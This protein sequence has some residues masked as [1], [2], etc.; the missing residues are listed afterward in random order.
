MSQTDTVRESTE[1]GTGRRQPLDD[2]SKRD[3]HYRCPSEATREMSAMN[4][5]LRSSFT[6][7]VVLSDYIQRT[8]Y[9]SQLSDQGM[10]GA[11]IPSSVELHAWL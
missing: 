1:E 3:T 10:L 11:H 4:L 5:T 6:S 8:I 7:R 2:L 9:I